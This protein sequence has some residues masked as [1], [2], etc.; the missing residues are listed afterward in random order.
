MPVGISARMQYCRAQARRVLA[1][2]APACFLGSCCTYARR[3][4]PA[5]PSFS[6]EIAVHLLAPAGGTTYVFTKAPVLGW[7]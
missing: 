7:C 3:Y 4:L 6:L 2:V 1:V 5:L